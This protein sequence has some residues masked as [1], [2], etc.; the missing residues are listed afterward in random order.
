MLR[1]PRMSCRAPLE[2]GFR[3]ARV[4][5]LGGTPTIAGRRAAG[6]SELAPSGSCAAAVQVHMCVR[7]AQCLS[8]QLATPHPLGQFKT[9]C[10][11]R[12]P[13]LRSPCMAH[14]LPVLQ[15]VDIFLLIWD[16][17]EAE[18]GKHTEPDRARGT[19]HPHPDCEGVVG[20]QALGQNRVI[21]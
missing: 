3:G 16:C 15:L 18:K 2:S 5:P 20:R 13:S 19:P 11:I 6:H 17:V 7:F 4:A 12:P 14:V 1:G 9:V 21:L 8:S 10:S